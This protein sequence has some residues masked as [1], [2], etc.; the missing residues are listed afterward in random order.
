M[1]SESQQRLSFLCKLLNWEYLKSE[2]F[3]IPWCI[4]KSRYLKYYLKLL[5][6]ER[7]S[8]ENRIVNISFV[9]TVCVS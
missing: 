5:S 2:G 8:G 4:F 3:V 6:T 9:C 1:E 7:C